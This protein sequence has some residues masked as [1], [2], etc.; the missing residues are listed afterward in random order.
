[1]ENQEAVTPELKAYID[2]LV[3][4]R[5]AKKIPHICPYCELFQFNKDHKTNRYCQYVGDL[6]VVNGICQM[7]RLAEDVGSRVRGNYTV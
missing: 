1:M 2:K 6:K 5:V 4:E 3:H 7:W